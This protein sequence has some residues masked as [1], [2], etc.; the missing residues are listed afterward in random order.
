M[1]GSR[2]NRSI[3][4]AARCRSSGLTLTVKG[5][6]TRALPPEATD[7]ERGVAARR[8]VRRDSQGHALHALVQNARHFSTRALRKSVAKTDP[9]AATATPI[10]DRISSASV[11]K[12][13]MVHRRNV[14]CFF[15]VDVLRN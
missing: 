11:P 15:I 2:E 3:E 10:A 9:S 7:A 13:R 6:V 4:H 12:T 14:V 1:G 5:D 8:I